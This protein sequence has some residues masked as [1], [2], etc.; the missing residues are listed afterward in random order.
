VPWHRVVNAAGR[1]SLRGHAAITQRLKLEQ[2]GVSVDI[3]GR[4]SLATHG[5]RPR[6][7]S[8]SAR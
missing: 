4:I 7:T 5:W 2:E 3:A 6:A 8:R 1:I